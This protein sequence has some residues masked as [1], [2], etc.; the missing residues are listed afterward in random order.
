MQLTIADPAYRER[1]VGHLRSV[2]FDVDT[3]GRNALDVLGRDGEETDEEALEPF[4]RVWGRI[5][6]D[7]EVGLRAPV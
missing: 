1:L 7:V 6:P 5:Y 3:F 2:G 4:M